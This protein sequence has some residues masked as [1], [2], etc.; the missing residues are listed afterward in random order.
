MAQEKPLV[1]FSNP[2]ESELPAPLVD[3]LYRDANRLASYS[4]QLFGSVTQSIETNQSTRHTSDRRTQVGPPTIGVL[5]GKSS[6]ETAEGQ[7]TTALPHD[8]VTSDLLT[9]LRLEGRVT[10][11]VSSA[12]HGSLVL[13]SGTVVFLD[14]NLIRTAALVTNDIANQSSTFEVGEISPEGEATVSFSLSQLFS[15][16][17]FPSA[18]LLQ[19]DEGTSV[20]GTL[21]ETGMEEPISTYYFK[22]GNAG[23]SNVHLLG[24]K[25]VANSSL[26]LGESTLLGI[27]QGLAQS[28]SDLLMPPDATRCHPRHT[29]RH[30]PRTLIHSQ[31]KSAAQIE[32]R[33]PVSLLHQSPHQFVN[34]RQLLR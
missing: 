26:T 16:F 19:S 27:T 20:C 2:E 29:H 9:Q 8:V 14:R 33:F 25:E 31:H 18:F 24:V 4:A 15:N 11:D 7:K 10:R 17:D 21:K 3:Y 12:P 6:Q 28:L 13:A 23:L 34:A 30:L 22:H 32:R 5:E 1:V